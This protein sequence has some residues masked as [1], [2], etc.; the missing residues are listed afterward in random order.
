[1]SII[2]ACNVE[3]A[4]AGAMDDIEAGRVRGI[5]EEPRKWGQGL[6]LHD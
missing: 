2:F 6:E 5:E 1:M 3:T 4:F